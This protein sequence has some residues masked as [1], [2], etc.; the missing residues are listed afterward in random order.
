MYR[1]KWAGLVASLEGSSPLSRAL[2]EIESE[3]GLKGSEIR[4]LKAGREFPVPDQKAGVR[5][6]VHPFLF[7][8]VAHHNIRVDEDY[9]E[10]K[11]I[12]PGDLEL[13]E[14]F[15]ALEEALLKVL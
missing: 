2:Q 11:W 5:W 3:T 7:E 8:A 15:P 4:F 6:I 10:Y 13:F 9:S 14:T 1:G 12:K